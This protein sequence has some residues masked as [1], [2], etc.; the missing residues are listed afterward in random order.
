[1]APSLDPSKWLV[2]G[3][4]DVFFKF[5]ML[6]LNILVVLRAQILKLDQSTVHNESSS[7]L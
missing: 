1:M 2:T 5:F 7:L 4:T 6:Y 3:V